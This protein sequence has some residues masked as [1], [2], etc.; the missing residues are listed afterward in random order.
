MTVWEDR[1]LLLACRGSLWWILMDLGGSRGMFVCLLAE[2]HNDNEDVQFEFFR[3][4]PKIE[5]RKKLVTFVW[6]PKRAF[7]EGFAWRFRGKPGETSF[8]LAPFP[9]GQSAEVGVVP[10][11]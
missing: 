9:T 10:Q 3:E 7:D 1:R 11:R 5:E 6:T 4:S 2:T 8:M